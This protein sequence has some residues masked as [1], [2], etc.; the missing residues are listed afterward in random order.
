MSWKCHPPKKRKESSKKSICGDG[1]AEG[2]KQD[3]DSCKSL[4]SARTCPLTSGTWENVRC[5]ITH[6]LLTNW[7]HHQSVVSAVCTTCH[8]TSTEPRL[9]LSPIQVNLFSL[10]PSS[11]FSWQVKVLQ[12]SNL[13]LFPVI[14]KSHFKCKAPS[15]T[16]VPPLQNFNYVCCHHP[17][18]VFQQSPSLS[19]SSPKESP[20]TH[21]CL[22]PVALVFKASS[23]SL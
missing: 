11:F 10:V 7:A 14:L 2:R 18:T 15:L 3:W 1:E 22:A 20:Y 17:T 13:P 19:A 16:L 6:S 4:L 12:L 21:R 8:T 23:F 5:L 9:P